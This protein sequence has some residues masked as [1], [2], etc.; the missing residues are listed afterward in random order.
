MIYVLLKRYKYDI[1]EGDKLNIRIKI[2]AAMILLSLIVSIV[3]G[4]TANFTSRDIIKRRS[5]GFLNTIVNEKVATIDSNLYSVEKLCVNMQNEFIDTFN[6]NSNDRTYIDKYIDKFELTVILNSEQN[7]SNSAFLIIFAGN[8]ERVIWYEDNNLDG[9]PDKENDINKQ[10][11]MLEVVKNSTRSEWVVDYEK[12]HVTLFKYIVNEENELVAVVGMNLKLV[13]LIRHIHRFEY[14]ETGKLFLTTEKNE[15]IYHPNKT[16]MIEEVVEITGPGIFITKADENGKDFI[17]SS[18]ELSNG[19]ILTISISKENLYSE[20]NKMTVV[21]AIMVLLSLIGIVIFSLITS[22]FIAEPYKYLTFTIESIGHGNYDI[23]ID[24]SYFKRSDEV[25]ILSRA[26]QEMV[27]LQKES[28]EEI[29]NYNTNL[30]KL[31]EDRTEKLSK[32]NFALENS[33]SII[34]EKQSDLKVTNEQLEE[35]LVQIKETRKELIKTEKIASSRY[36]AIGIAHNM[37]TPLGN[38]ITMMSFLGTKAKE[39]LF[40]FESGRLSKTKL[41]DLFGTIDE[42]CSH[43]ESNNEQMKSLI[44]KLKNLSTIKMN[45]NIQ[46]I[47]IGDTIG[48][49]VNKFLSEHVELEFKINVINDAKQKIKIDAGDL[50]KIIYELIDNSIVHGF[51]NIELP[52]ININVSDDENHNVYITYKDN[53]SGVKQD[54]IQ[55]V[56][57]PLFTTKLGK[58]HGL[59]LAMV[60]NIV[61]EIFKGEISIKSDNQSGTEILIKLHDKRSD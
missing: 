36:I 8:Q 53:G 61:I 6:F 3:I 1:E 48:V 52:E 13:E 39:L 35:S 10:N 59:G 15:V 56:F 55:E 20:L 5:E 26:I 37:N 23:N 24:E 19:W 50:D 58:H 11:E 27:K 29:K 30:E 49:I 16:Q 4:M 28:F 21:I 54:L 12:L 25:G 47:D 32:S 9:V 18:I 17:L 41:A 7:S 46:A 43:V 57:T 60:H 42:V 38:I 33:L 51:E 22:R 40:E 45:T 44:E 2:G 34:K 31:V 14:L